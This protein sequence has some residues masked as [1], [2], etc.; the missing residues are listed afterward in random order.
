MTDI[1]RRLFMGLAAVSVAF[2]AWGIPSMATAASPYYKGKTITVLVGTA[3]GGG[4]DLHTRL[5]ARH[6][7]KHI[8]GNPQIIVKSMPGGGGA[9]VLNFLYERAKPDGQTVVWGPWN[10]AGVILGSPGLRYVP[11]KFEFIGAGGVFFVT[12][13]RTDIPPGIKKGSDIVKA[14]GFKIGGRRADRALDLTGN[15]ALDMIGAKY[16]FVPGYRGMARINPAIRRNEVQGGNSGMSGYYIFFKDTMIKQGQ[17]IA[18][19]YH[20][21]FDLNGNIGPR[22]KGFPPSMKSFVEVYEEVHGKKPS[23]HLWEAYKWFSTKVNAMTF[24]MSAPPGSPKEAVAA[25]RKGHLAT[26]KDPAYVKPLIKRFGAETR[27]VSLEQGLNVL[28]TYRNVDPEVLAVFKQ[29][30]KKGKK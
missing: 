16:Q 30:A 19:W 9:K 2:T 8:P 5:F 21:T 27:W 10:A 15:L 1:V 7:R 29:M 14:Q 25:L 3:P 24:T 6:W 28:K 18:L 12:I 26:T 22:S 11:E 4:L 20:P 13:V 23:G 17:A